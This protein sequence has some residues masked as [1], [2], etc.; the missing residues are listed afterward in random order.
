MES[1]VASE[2]GPSLF[3]SSHSSSG[4]LGSLDSFLSGDGSFFKMTELKW[5]C[6]N[7]EN[8]RNK[9][10][11]EFLRIHKKHGFDL[12]S[13]IIAFSHNESHLAVGVY[14][15]YG[16]TLAVAVAAGVN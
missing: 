4:I 7:I 6:Q 14:L 5:L 11:S 12:S 8:L 2:S 13:P 16:G 9:E 15:G 3:D 1:S 10:K